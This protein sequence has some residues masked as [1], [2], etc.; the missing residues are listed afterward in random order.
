MRNSPRKFPELL[1]EKS[2]VAC[3]ESTAR[4][5]SLVT[6]VPSRAPFLPA[7]SSKRC[8]AGAHDFDVHRATAT[9][10]FKPLGVGAPTRECC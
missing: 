6:A 5:S 10:P 8:R 2:S 9:A 1:I 3:Y 7:A 4:H